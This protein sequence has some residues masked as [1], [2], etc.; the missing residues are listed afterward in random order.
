MRI[1]DCARKVEAAN[2]REILGDNLFEST[3]GVYAPLV[4]EFKS[5]KDAAGNQYTPLDN[6]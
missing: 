4:N 2:T 3:D 6:S 1:E 5:W